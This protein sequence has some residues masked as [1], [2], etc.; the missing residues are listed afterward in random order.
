MISTI[1][2][3]ASQYHVSNLGRSR[4]SLSYARY[5]WLVPEYDATPADAITSFDIV[6]E[7]FA[8]PNLDDLAKGAGGDY[9]Y[10]IPARDPR[11]PRKV[12]QVILLRS[13]SA[14]DGI[15][16]GWSGKTI[17]INKGR[18]KTY[19]YLVWKSV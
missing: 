14:I 7:S 12:T 9:R 15:P 2:S 8:D 10:I 4:I 3:V 1:S 19:L 13:D 17:D 6:I 18:G 16:A 5:V 11:E